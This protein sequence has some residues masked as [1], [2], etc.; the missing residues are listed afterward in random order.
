MS[1]SQPFH[2]I[3]LASLTRKCLMVIGTGGQFGGGNFQQ[4]GVHRVAGELV[5]CGGRVPVGEVD[6][7]AVLKGMR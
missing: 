6:E 4:D 1:D 2:A 3:C 7:R 5:V